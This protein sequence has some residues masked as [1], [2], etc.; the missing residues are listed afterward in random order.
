[1]VVLLV[2]HYVTSD[3]RELSSHWACALIKLGS[4]ITLLREVLI[5]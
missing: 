1:M 2:F 5:F 3:N 4:V